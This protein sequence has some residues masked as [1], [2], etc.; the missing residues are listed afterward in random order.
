[1]R[2]MMTCC[3]A[4]VACFAGGT[5]AMAATATATSTATLRIGTGT[6]CSV[7][8]ANLSLGT[9]KPTETYQ[10]VGDFLGSLVAGEATLNRGVLAPGAMT[11]G[12]VTCQNGIPYFIEMKGSGPYAEIDVVLP[13]GRLNLVPMVK[14]IGAYTVPDGRPENNGFG[15][16]AAPGWATAVE[17]TDRNPLGTTGNGEEQIIMGNLLAYLF[18]QPDSRGYAARTAQLGAAGTYTVSW[19]TVVYF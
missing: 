2:K 1:M 3:A 16:S 9:Y 14:R 17:Y 13:S 5:A 10:T 7:K 12:S 19:N 11:M 4:L 6:E 8:G 15:K 18:D